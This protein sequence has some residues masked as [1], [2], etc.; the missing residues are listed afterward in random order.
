MTLGDV[1]VTWLVGV[2]ALGAG[3]SRRQERP[4]PGN[5][6][7]GPSP[8]S[9]QPV[10]LPDLSPMESPVQQQIRDRQAALTEKLQTPGTSPAEL[11][12]AYGNL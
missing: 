10:V 4:M 5:A 12:V 3:C 7:E 6:Q 8:T 11:A 1:A 9:L 2:V